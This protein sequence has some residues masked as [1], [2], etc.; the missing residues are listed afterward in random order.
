M[1]DSR[2]GTQ[3]TDIEHCTGVAESWRAQFKSD[4]RN[5]DVLA[6]GGY[7]D[8]ARERIALYA[9]YLRKGYPM[10]TEHFLRLC[11]WLDRIAAGSEPAVVLGT[12][13]RPGKMP[14]VETLERLDRIAQTV[15]ALNGG[16]GNA[17]KLPL[18]DSRTQVNGVVDGA[19]TEAAKLH[20]VAASTARQAW[21]V[22]GQSYS[23]L[24]RTWEQ[25]PPNLRALK[26]PVGSTRRRKKS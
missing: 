2:R 13:K 19:F 5:L 12:A 15:F 18:N 22:Y 26:R 3:C 9:K 10:P 17:Q 16:F 14:S 7:S 24:V 6:D 8:A 11:D 25:G 1:K 21:E 23:A 4:V 20:R